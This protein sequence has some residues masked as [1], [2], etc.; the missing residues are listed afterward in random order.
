MKKII[1]VV[2]TSLLFVGCAS[3]NTQ[4]ETDWDAWETL[5]ANKHE[6]IETILFENV[7]TETYETSTN[8]WD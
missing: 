8:Y 6:E 2:L 5:V 4:K 7:E 3:S 1:L